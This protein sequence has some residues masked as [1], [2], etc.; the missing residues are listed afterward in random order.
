M[1]GTSGERWRRAAVACG[2]ARGAPRVTE[3]GQSGARSSTLRGEATSWRGVPR[4][5]AWRCACHTP[6]GPAPQLTAARTRRSAVPPDPVGGSPTD[7]VWNRHRADYR[8][9]PDT[10]SALAANGADGGLATRAPCPKPLGAGRLGR[11][12][13]LPCGWRP[14]RPPTPLVPA[15]RAA[16]RYPGPAAFTARDA[17]ASTRGLY[18]QTG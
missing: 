3:V 9:R 18:R 14:D 12:A 1:A 4:Q 15:T 10:E 7:A 17:L 11:S 8:T 6:S 5:G 16:Y 2:R 13:A